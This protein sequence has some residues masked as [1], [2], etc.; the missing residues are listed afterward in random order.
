MLGHP[1]GAA[2]PYEP[3]WA[4]CGPPPTSEGLTGGP[5]DHHLR[6]EGLGCGPE[7]G[8][9]RDS[10]SWQGGLLMGLL[11]ADVPRNF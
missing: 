3:L 10:A 8:L 4:F 5:S 7:T 11:I 9:P 6:W 2:G 1:R